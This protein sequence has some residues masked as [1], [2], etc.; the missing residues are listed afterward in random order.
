M[1]FRLSSHKKNGQRTKSVLI[2]GKE[3]LIGS[4]DKADIQLQTPEGSA[5][6]ISENNGSLTITVKGVTVSIK[7]KDISDGSV[8]AGSGTQFECLEQS[9]YVTVVISGDP[10]PRKK[11][12]LSALAL[13]LIWTLLGIQ[14]I[15]PIWLPYKITGHKVKGRNVLIENCSKGLDDL[16]K[17]Y[18]KKKGDLGSSS[19]INRDI[20]NRLSDEVEQMAWVFRNAGEFMS[21]SEL[22]QLEKDIMS[23][24]L[25]LA[26]VKN[27]GSVSV[28]PVTIE[29]AV[30][31]LLKTEQ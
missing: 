17:K 15:V 31:N 9:F 6:S 3:A 29:N 13:A 7:G 28:E 19:Q 4:S 30:R 23:Y 1:A 24:N 5:I 16:R 25:I 21:K 27:T 2:E 14:L 8:S 26:E 10:T 12:Y 22:L 20:I 11:G 18:T